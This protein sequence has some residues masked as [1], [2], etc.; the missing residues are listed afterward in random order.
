LSPASRA[1]SL[2]PRRQHTRHPAP[3]LGRAARRCPPPVAPTQAA[4]SPPARAPQNLAV[5]QRRRPAPPE[6]ASDFDSQPHTCAAKRSDRRLRLSSS[7]RQGL[8]GQGS[9]PQP[10]WAERLTKR[11][12]ERIFLSRSA[13]ARRASARASARAGGHCSDDPAPLQARHVRS[14]HA[15][16]CPHLGCQLALSG[17]ARRSHSGPPALPLRT[18]A[19]AAPAAVELHHVCGTMSGTRAGLSLPPGPPPGGGREGGRPGRHREAALRGH[20]FG[21]EPR[22]VH[23]PEQPFEVRAVTPANSPPPPSPPPPPPRGRTDR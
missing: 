20:V 8:Q 10:V 23:L 14:F 13:P 18:P 21:D 4:H 11:I 12:F 3:L 16:P 9:P 17:A 1:R 7:G 15:R 22:A 19:A 5:R 2:A 6:T